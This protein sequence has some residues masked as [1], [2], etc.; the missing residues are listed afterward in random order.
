MAASLGVW[1]VGLPHTNTVSRLSVYSFLPFSKVYICHLI[2]YI[3]LIID[4]FPWT[5]PALPITA[6][7]YRIPSLELVSSCTWHSPSH[8]SLMV[9]STLVEC[10][11]RKIV[12]RQTA[13]LCTT[14]S[15]EQALDLITPDDG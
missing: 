8:G 11:S 2:H 14:Q 9:H 12:K 4:S 5:Y 15:C 6:G 3:K 13:C 7:R 1:L 10:T